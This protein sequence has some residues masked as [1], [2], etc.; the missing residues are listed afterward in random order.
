[1]TYHFDLVAVCPV[2]RGLAQ[3]ATLLPP[4]RF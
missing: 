1:M 3:F 2:P 4:L